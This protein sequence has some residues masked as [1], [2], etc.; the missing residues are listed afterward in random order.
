MPRKK[1]G[2]ETPISVMLVE[3]RSTTELRFTADR[4]PIPSAKVIEI[5]SAARQSSKVD[6]HRSL[7]ARARAENA[8]TVVSIFGNPR[9]F[10][11]PADLA[12]YPRN[13]ARDVALGAEGGADIG[14][15][16]AVDEG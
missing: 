9:Q 12:R 7:I 11:D 6:G 8:T 2:N 3:S 5:R 16:P 1:L 13:E 10:G 4:I 14:L 15:A